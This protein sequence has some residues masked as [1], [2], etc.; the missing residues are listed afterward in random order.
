MERAI[1]NY[2]KA[3][4]LNPKYNR[5]LLNKGIAL[6]EDGRTKEAEEWF[7]KISLQL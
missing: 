7:W 5:P 4:Q 6:V 2:E 1:E 3:I